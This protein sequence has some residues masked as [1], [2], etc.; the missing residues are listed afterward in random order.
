MLWI[1]NY[2]F[3]NKGR[4]TYSQTMLPME[5]DQVQDK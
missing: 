1:L 5:L 3:P 2:V 4:V